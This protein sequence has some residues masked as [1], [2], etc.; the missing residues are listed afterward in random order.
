MRYFNGREFSKA[1]E[2]FDRLIAGGCDRSNLDVELARFYAAEAHTKLGLDYLSH[3]EYDLARAEFRSA[4]EV[5]GSFPDLYFYLGN[6]ARRDGECAEALPLLDRAL[7]LNPMHR[8]ALACRALARRGTGAAAAARDDL[9]RLVAACFPM[10]EA[11]AAQAR[12]PLRASAC[13]VPGKRPGAL[14]PVLAAYDRGHLGRAL[15]LLGE[16]IEDAPVYADL[17]FRR[18]RLLTE[19]N[20]L[21]EAV[22][23]Y[24]AALGLNP[25]YVQ[26]ALAR[27]VC[28]LSLNRPDRAERSLAH[29]AGLRP[30]YADVA[31]Y[32]GVSLAR[33]GQLREALAPLDRALDRNPGFWRAHFVAGQLHASLGDLERGFDCLDRALAHFHPEPREGIAAGDENGFRPLPAVQRLAAAAAAHPGYADLRFDLGLARLEAGDRAGAREAFTQAIALNPGFVAAHVH[34]GMIEIQAGKPA[35]A[36]P[37]LARALDA[38][39]GRA[40]VLRLLGDCRLAA[41]DP[42]DAS[43][44]YERALSANPDYP[45]ALAGLG[46]VR[47]SQRRNGEAKELFRRVREMDPEFSVP[48]MRARVLPELEKVGS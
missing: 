9:M 42:E 12:P 33:M 45:A 29:A 41:G 43:R 1:L 14:D 28:L 26:A 25:D 44:A 34:L 10:P 35:A 24:D 20:R 16:A 8:E 30:G 5:E 36:A 15:D 19:M 21:H 3:N 6:L 17:R 37:H 38:A 27:G 47:L 7:E 2:E 31:F 18:G 46:K 23:S 39:P 11:A 13:D 48:R 32:H 40:D 22:A 4:L